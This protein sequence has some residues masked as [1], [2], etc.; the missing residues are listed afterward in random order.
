M[1]LWRNKFVLLGIFLCVTGA[2]TVFLW[3]VASR[4]QEPA[5]PSKAVI[6]DT[7]E[8]ES[9]ELAVQLEKKPGHTPIL[10]RL[11]QLEH[12]QGKLDDAAGHLREV[13]KN[14]PGNADAHLELGRILYEKNDWNA[15]IT[16]TQ[17]ALAINPKQVDALYNLGAIYANG[18]D[19]ERARS[20]WRSAMSVDPQSDS[21]QRARQSLSKLSKAPGSH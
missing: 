12:D 2:G 13:L 19:T 18:G 7:P 8:H 21:G 14:E 17:K 15:A 4:V 6:K 3:R 9:K 11:A 20:L 10:L 16:E 5:V 1:K